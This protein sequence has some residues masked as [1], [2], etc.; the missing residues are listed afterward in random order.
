MV[1]DGLEDKHSLNLEDKHSLNIYREDSIEP[2]PFQ[3]SISVTPSKQEKFKRPKK[4]G[5]IS[6]NIESPN[7]DPKN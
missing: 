7:A 4:V 1:M 6:S 5:S 2:L 3:S